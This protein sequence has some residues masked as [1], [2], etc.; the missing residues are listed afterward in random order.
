MRKKLQQKNETLDSVA[1]HIVNSG[2]RINEFYTFEFHI[3]VGSF[4]KIIYVTSQ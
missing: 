4:I 3:T 2:P 1:S